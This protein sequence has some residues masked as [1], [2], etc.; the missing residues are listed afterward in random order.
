M[1]QV[2]DHLS[3][4]GKKQKQNK[5][6]LSDPYYEGITYNNQDMND[7]TTK[8]SQSSPWQ[9]SGC[10]TTQTGRQLLIEH[11]RICDHQIFELDI[12]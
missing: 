7:W 2:F 1:S 11:A 9:H 6:F 3:D 4:M 10:L 5:K 8:A 12:Y